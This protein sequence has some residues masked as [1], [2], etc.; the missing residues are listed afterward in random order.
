MFFSPGMSFS[1]CQWFRPFGFF[2]G[3][4][5]PPIPILRDFDGKICVENWANDSF[6]FS[7]INGR[8]SVFLQNDFVIYFIIGLSVW[9][10]GDSKKVR[11]AWISGDGVKGGKLFFSLI[12]F[13][14][15][16]SFWTRIH[17][18][19]LSLVERLDFLTP[20]MDLASSWVQLNTHHV[21]KFITNMAFIWTIKI[22]N[23]GNLK[24]IFFIL[25]FYHSNWENL[26]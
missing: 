11:S 26:L 20:L 1:N 4:L 13:C 17:S 9:L 10:F 3:S 19:S 22:S 24:N 18:L 15:L 23:E 6:E 12:F 25:L 8:P 7:L 16:S 21:N 14:F 2:K 5:T